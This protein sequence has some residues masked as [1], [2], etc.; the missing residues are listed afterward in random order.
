VSAFLSS[1]GM[2]EVIAGLA[3]LALNVYALLGGADFGG[4]VWDLLA[5]GPRREEQRT[6]IADSIGPIWEANHVWLIV[7][8]VVLFTAFPAAFEALGVVLHVPLTI[9]LVGVVLRGSAFMFRSYGSRSMHERHQWG[10]A[11]AMASVVTPVL[12]GVIIGAISSG[13][14]GRAALGAGSGSFV[15]VYVRPWAAPFPFAV[16]GFALSIF[17]Y[18]A[19]VYATVAAKTDPLREDFRMRALAAAVAVFLF[20]ALSLVF[21]RVGGA[22]RVAAGIATSPWSIPLHLCTATAAVTAIVALVRRRYSRARVA[23]AAQVTFILWGWALAEYP[24]LVP[25]SLTIRDAAAPAITLKLLLIGLAA[26]ALILIPSLRYMLKIF[27]A[28]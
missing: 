4:G 14:V 28:R 9:M 21:A 6:L 24:Y 17:A 5:S 27:A 23:A 18:L 12:L 25:E 22:P 1:I 15:N 20:A 7:V 2:P 16:G 8:V 3:L 10:A 13:N 11:F 19:A 26:G